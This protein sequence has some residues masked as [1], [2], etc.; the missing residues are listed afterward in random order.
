MLVRVFQPAQ[1]PAALFRFREMEKEFPHE[2]SV[3]HQMAFKGVDVLEPFPPKVFRD[4]RRRQFLAGQQLGMHP[5]HQSLL[6]IGAVEY[7]DAPALR[8]PPVRAPQEIMVQLL[9]GRY[10]ERHHVATLRVDARH[11]VFDGTVLAGGIHRLEDHQHGPLVLGVKLVLQFAQPGDAL[12]QPFLRVLLGLQLPCVG[13]ID[14]C[15]PEFPVLGD[16][17]A[18]NQLCSFHSCLDLYQRARRALRPQPVTR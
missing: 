13:R 6:V 1:E 14:V 5:H 4:Q 15:Q 16:A 7:P 12:L 8:Q 3:A 10:F 17:I 2:H 11:D 9:L 18:C